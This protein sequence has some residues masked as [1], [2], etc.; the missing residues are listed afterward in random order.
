VL[1]AARSGPV[2]SGADKADALATAQ[3]EARFAR[4]VHQLS[5]VGTASEKGAISASKVEPPAVTIW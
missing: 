2:G 4:L 5:A 3:V 1:R